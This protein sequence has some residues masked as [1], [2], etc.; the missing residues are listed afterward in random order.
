[1][2]QSHSRLIQMEAKVAQNLRKDAAELVNVQQF[3]RKHVG[4][5]KYQ[6]RHGPE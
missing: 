5:L 6:S 4:M 2:C 3:C 1:M